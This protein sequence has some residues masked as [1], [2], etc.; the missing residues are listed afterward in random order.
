MNNLKKYDLDVVAEVLS[1]Y[2]F[3]LNVRAEM[4]SVEVFVDLSNALMK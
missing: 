1:K 3:D 4:L 2:G